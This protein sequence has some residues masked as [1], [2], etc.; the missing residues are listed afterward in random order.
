[1]LR[2]PWF[3]MKSHG[4]RMCMLIESPAAFRES[5]IFISANALSRA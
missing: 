5:K 2:N 3:A 4:G 1:M